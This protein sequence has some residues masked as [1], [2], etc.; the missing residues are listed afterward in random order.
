MRKSSELVYMN[1][2]G[3]L[4]EFCDPADCS[5]VFIKR[6][7]VLEFEAVLINLVPIYDVKKNFQYIVDLLRMMC[8]S[9]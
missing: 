9:N 8:G 3:N 2:L 5:L 4:S 6:K 7:A 1:A